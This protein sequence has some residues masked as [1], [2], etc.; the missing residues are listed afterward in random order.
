[1]SRRT[2]TSNGN[3]Q[4]LKT[5]RI[6]RAK[7][8][9]QVRATA[10]VTQQQVDEST[11]TSHVNRTVV[12]FRVTPL[13]VTEPVTTHISNYPSPFELLVAKIYLFIHPS[14]SFSHLKRID[15]FVPLRIIR[16]RKILRSPSPF[17]SVVTAFPS[18]YSMPVYFF[19]ALRVIR[20]RIF[21]VAH[22]GI[23]L[24]MYI[25][26]FVHPSSASSAHAVFR[27]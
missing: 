21:S 15:L 19:V 5:P 16:R 4:L 20:R 10:R 8:N 23:R 3:T 17:E 18:I 22:R 26:L 1:M 24:R 27:S 2:V 9:K 25:N 14:S 6:S 11:Q 7:P 12:T 13:T